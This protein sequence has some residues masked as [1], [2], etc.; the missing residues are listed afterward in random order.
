MPVQLHR[1]L[2]H[3]PLQSTY[4]PQRPSK[5]VAVIERATQIGATL[6][7]MQDSLRQ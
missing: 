3:T 4:C 6:L 5:R 7:L 1:Q 2:V